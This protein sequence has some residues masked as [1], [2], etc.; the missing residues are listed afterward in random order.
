MGV[1]L[2][3]KARADT[4]RRLGQRYGP[5]SRFIF[6][7][8]FSR[9]AHAK[10]RP[11]REHPRTDLR[12][13]HL[14][15]ALRANAKRQ[16]SNFKASRRDGA[17]DF[18]VWPFGFW[19]L[20]RAARPPRLRLHRLRT[21]WLYP[22]E[23]TARWKFVMRNRSA[24][25]ADSHGLPR[26]P[27]WME[28]TA[29]ERRLSRQPNSA[30]QVFRPARPGAREARSFRAGKFRAPHSALIAGHALAAWGDLH[31]RDARAISPQ[32]AFAF[33]RD[34]SPRVNPAALGAAGRRRAGNGAVRRSRGDAG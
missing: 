14:W 28:R 13:S 8:K 4:H 24:T 20:L 1:C 22:R 10:M 11:T 26:C 23:F 16:W 33:F 30:Q 29:N 5:L 27:G 7:M 32:S 25:V 31:S 2:I 34:R 6:A 9:T 21:D 19:D 12:T 3:V 17:A 18:G 15:R